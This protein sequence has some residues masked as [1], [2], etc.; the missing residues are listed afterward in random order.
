MPEGRQDEAIANQALCHPRNAVEQ[1]LVERRKCL[2]ADP[3]LP[4]MH[5]GTAR[6]RRRCGGHVAVFHARRPLH[7]VHVGDLV[8][9]RWRMR[10]GAYVAAAIGD[11]SMPPACWK[12]VNCVISM[13]FEQHLPADARARRERR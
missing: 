11:S 12:Y 2:A 5:T 3:D 10:S 9:G 7:V 13:P 4:R 6:P 8:R 1:I